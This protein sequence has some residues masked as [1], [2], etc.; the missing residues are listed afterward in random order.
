MSSAIS[1]ICPAWQAEATLA[2]TLTSVWAQIVGPAEIVV[3]DDGSSDG[4]AAIAAVGGAKVISQPHTGQPA[5]LNAGVAASSGELLAFIDADD[6][7][8]ADKLAA[9]AH[10]LGTDP[11]LSGVLG[12]VQS[13]L[14]PE[15]EPAVA[16][17]YRLPEHLQPAWLPGA[18]LVHRSAFDAVG[19][20][21]EAIQAGSHIDWFDRARHLGLTLAMPNRVVLLRRIRTGSLSHRSPA[22]DAG[23]RQMARRALQRRANGEAE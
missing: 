3:V 21:D 14:S 16:S 12:L 13:F 4:T 10:L 22:R 6:L 19:P 20:F 11:A 18:L 15:L 17:R 8:P 23:Y 9:Q 7:W 2:E 5:A 1:V